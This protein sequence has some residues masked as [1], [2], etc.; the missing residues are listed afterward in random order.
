MKLSA[1][2]LFCRQTLRPK[3][4]WQRPTEVQLFAVLR[5]PTFACEIEKSELQ[6]GETQQPVAGLFPIAQQ[7]KFASGYR[8]T[9]TTHRTSGPQLHGKMS[10]L[11]LN[12]IMTIPLYH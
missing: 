12:S 11:T 8:G 7:S 9:M 1:G 5:H 4:V 10:V 3:S 6:L 2:K